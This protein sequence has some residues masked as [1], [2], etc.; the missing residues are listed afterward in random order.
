M[1]VESEH[2]TQQRSAVSFYSSDSLIA[3]GG[4]LIILAVLMMAFSSWDSITPFNRCIGALIPLVALYAIGFSL[5]G[6]VEHA[7]LSQA[8]LLIGSAIFP[9]VLGIILYQSGLLHS[10]AG[11]SDPVL[12]FI[13]SLISLAWFL[14][15]EFVFNQKWHGVLTAIVSLTILSSLVQIILP[16]DYVEPLLG[17]LVAYF[18]LTAAWYL[19]QSA[20]EEQATVYAVMGAAFGLVSLFCLPFSYFAD[21][22]GLPSVVAYVGIAG[23]L[24]LVAALY[25][26]EYRINHKVSVLLVRRAA[27]QSS[28]IIL[29][30]PAI[31]ALFNHYDF[32]YSLVA[33]MLALFS[34]CIAH[35]V[36][37]QAFR[38]FGIFGMV[39]SGIALLGSIITNSSALWPII[40]LVIGFI[41][42]GMAYAQQHA[43][44]T[45]ITKAFALPS[46]NSLFD[47]GLTYNLPPAAPRNTFLSS[48]QPGSIIVRIV[49]VL[50]LA[51]FVLSILGILFTLFITKI[52]S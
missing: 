3:L 43:P 20:R 2:S 51:P 37:V 30:V 25:G 40:L 42:M 48:N 4:I 6:K 38:I 33:F 8:S 27:E 36:K 14:V 50:L 29:T 44:L 39:I 9:F 16:P 35:F 47:L 18:A 5:R 28:A 49:L 7:R 11:A 31:F 46:E 13:V 1:I 24:F 52:N 22:F 17:L 19:G 15:M 23:L 34:E 12:A 26:P 21:A 41:L 32:G 10:D 45:L